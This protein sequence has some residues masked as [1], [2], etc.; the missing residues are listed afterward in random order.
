MVI[1]VWMGIDGHAA[2]SKE[3]G[4]SNNNRSQRL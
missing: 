2:V 3:V 4:N 1:G